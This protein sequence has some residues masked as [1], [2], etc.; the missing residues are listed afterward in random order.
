MYNLHGIKLITS[1]KLHYYVLYVNTIKHIHP[2]IIL[3]TLTN[4]MCFAKI[5]INVF[6]F[7]GNSEFKIEDLYDFLLNF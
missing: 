5:V 2:Q 1:I 4:F 7:N 6:C 3:I